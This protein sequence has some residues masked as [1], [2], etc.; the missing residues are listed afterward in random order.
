MWANWQDCHDHDDVDKKNIDKTHHEAVTDGVD[1]VDDPFVFNLPA[2]GGTPHDDSKCSKDVEGPCKKCVVE[3][4][5]WCGSNDFDATCLGFCAAAACLEKCGGKM[6]TPRTPKDALKYWETDK[7]TPRA[8]HSIH[9]Q[10]DRSYMYY[11]DEFEDVFNQATGGNSV[12]KMDIK[13]RLLQ[14]G[15]EDIAKVYRHSKVSPQRR[16]L[17]D[18]HHEDIMREGQRRSTR[19]LEAP[20]AKLNDGLGKAGHTKVHGCKCKSFWATNDFSCTTGCCADPM[21]PNDGGVCVVE[22][23]ECE[24]HTWGYCNMLGSQEDP[25]HVASKFYKKAYDD[26]AQS[27][28]AMRDSTKAQI[29]IPKLV[30]LECKLL[31][32]DEK[33]PKI[34]DRLWKMLG[35]EDID[36]EVK[37]S[38][39]M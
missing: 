20:P 4:D 3:Q 18:A 15:H 37:N 30:E 23:K 8:Y 35:M 22:D 10:G 34:D 27:A 6:G 21:F 14:T 36:D 5:S 13:K 12:C 1:G 2:T 24:G 29:V 17:L 31:Y 28:V 7:N 32:G 9:D 16:A 26:L 11:P 25:L 33:Q 19:R 39:C 38:P